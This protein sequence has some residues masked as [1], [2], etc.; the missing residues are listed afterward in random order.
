MAD[1]LRETR[2]MM[3][4]ALP[5]PPLP[6]EVDRVEDGTCMTSG[7]KA[8]TTV[9]ALIAQCVNACALRN[10]DAAN[11]ER[12]NRQHRVLKEFLH[13]LAA[14]GFLWDDE[15]L[16]DFY[17][18]FCYKHLCTYF[19]EDAKPDVRFKPWDYVVKGDACHNQL[20][21]YYRAQ[22]VIF[23]EEVIADVSGLDVVSIL[24]LLRD[25]IGRSE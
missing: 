23:E 1:P 24:I 20:V 18:Q 2:A 8:V 22:G 21:D 16:Y 19:P 5:Y 9:H 13:S 10:D 25:R 6:V 11:F 4:S 14:K 12:K 7:V 3:L 17:C 15:R